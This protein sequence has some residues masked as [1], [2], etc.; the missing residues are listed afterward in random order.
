ML[1]RRNDTGRPTASSSGVAGHLAPPG[2]RPGRHS[3]RE[4]TTVRGGAPQRGRLVLLVKLERGVE[5][6]HRVLSPVA[7]NDAGDLDI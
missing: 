5:H 2:T 4:K 1:L 7:R 6:L 3:L